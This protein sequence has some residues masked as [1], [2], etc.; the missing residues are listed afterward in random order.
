MTFKI[1]DY[2]N[3]GVTTYAYGHDSQIHLIHEDG[4]LVDNS[5][6]PVDDKTARL[7]GVDIEKLRMQQRIK[8]RRAEMEQRI[9]DMVAAEEAALA[10]A[11]P[12]K[13]MATA[14]T[15]LQQPPVE[16]IAK[17]GERSHP[18]WTQIGDRNRKS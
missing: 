12:D 1:T 3:S 11:N 17:A 6:A 13:P 14:D 16:E 4:R 15:T 9:R 2:Y 7:A 5:G 18:Q 10:A 8:D